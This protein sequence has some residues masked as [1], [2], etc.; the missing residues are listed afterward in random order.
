MRKKA[1]KKWFISAVLVI[2]FVSAAF[3]VYL[4]F[5]SEAPTDKLVAYLLAAGKKVYSPVT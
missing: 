3:F 5:S 2:V 4:S 1:L